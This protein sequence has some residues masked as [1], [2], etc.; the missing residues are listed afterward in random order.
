MTTAVPVA[1]AIPSKRRPALLL[2][3]TV[4]AFVA[5][6][7]AAIAKLA[8]KADSSSAELSIA[9]ISDLGAWWML[10]HLLW[11]TPSVLAILGLSGLADRAGPRALTARG[12]LAFVS[13]ALAA[14]YL[15]VQAMAYV[16]DTPTW[17]DSGW[18]V[19]GVAVSLAVGWLGTIPAT[20]LTA[21]GLA[22]R[23]VI[24]RTSRL[25]A[26]VCGVYLVWE[27]V[28]YAAVAFTSATLLDTS[29]P[30]PFLLGL[31]WATLGARLWWADHSKTEPS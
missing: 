14:T 3:L 16:V 19:V 10:V 28:T 24:P 7:G 20:V 15:L 17:G 6:L 18:Y 8:T 12:T 11:V 25:L 30:P 31:V 27:V 21:L 5:Y 23:G 2:V 26:V 29:G 1:Q 9:Q 4:P 22:R 13:I